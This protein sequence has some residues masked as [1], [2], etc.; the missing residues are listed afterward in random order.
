MK[1]SALL[2]LEWLEAR[3]APAQFGVPWPDPT[4]LT[5][6]FVPDGTLLAG[7]QSTLFTGLGTRFGSTAWQSAVLRAVE[8]WTQAANIN[9]GLVADS[10][11]PLG[12]AGAIQHD[13]RFGDLRISGAPL[14]DSVLGTGEPFDPMAGTWSGDIEFNTAQPFA[15]GGLDLYTVALHEVGHALGLGES[16]DPGSVMYEAYRGPRQG[17][18]AG[19]VLQ[20]QQLYGARQEDAFDL[21]AANDSPSTATRLTVPAADP[22]T[23][24]ADL[25]TPSDVDYYQVQVPGQVRGATIRLHVAGTSLLAGRLTILGPD[26]STATA[27]GPGQDLEVTSSSLSAGHT[28]LIRVDSTDTDFAV[29]AY[30]LEVVPLTEASHSAHS[31]SHTPPEHNSSGQ[32]PVI[33]LQARVYR[34]GLTF[35]YYVEDSLA[36]AQTKTYRFLAPADPGPLTVLAWSAQPGSFRPHLTLLDSQGE[37]VEASVLINQDGTYMLQMAQ[38][39]PGTPYLLRVEGAQAGSYAVGILFDGEPAALTP[40][41]IDSP[42]SAA[43]DVAGTLHVVDTQLM[44]FVFAA[45]GPA[46]VEVLD[47]QGRLVSSLAATSAEPVT[48]T[49]YLPAGDYTVRLAGTGQASLWVAALSS[50]LGPDAADVRPLPQSLPAGAPTLGFSWEL[51]VPL[52]STSAGPAGPVLPAG[53]GIPTNPVSGAAAPPAAALVPGGQAPPTEQVPAA[54]SL[55]GPTAT[56]PAAPARSVVSG[57]TASPPPGDGTVVSTTTAGA[58]PGNGAPAG[59][60]PALPRSGPGSLTG[61]AKDAVLPGPGFVPV[62]SGAGVFL[63][64]TSQAVA[65]STVAGGV[66][67]PGVQALLPGGSG[68]GPG[69]AVLPTPAVPPATADLV[70]PA[71]P[72]S[73]ATQD[74]R[75]ATTRPAVPAGDPAAPGDEP[76]AAVVAEPDPVATPAPWSWFRYTAAVAGVVSVTALW[77]LQRLVSDVGRRGP[78]A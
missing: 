34:D 51:N 7:Q 76:P 19:D 8:T 63:A 74:T 61:A 57:T 21:Q 67:G 24:A 65:G 73:P 36:T 33:N 41:V 27:T 38:S 68:T 58:P 6:S 53:A 4:H 35:A 43:G 15:P 37:P 1:S 39:S 16:S 59:V 50:P 45:Q 9:V 14:G 44:H 62:L 69:E 71:V 13:S 46:Q 25:T 3:L 70:L 48:M 29:G 54:P 28:L 11:L 12:T 18:S 66:P 26:G 72:Q 5:L 23:F 2:G 64:P 10:G 75:L 52:L 77:L 49:L 60:A 47:A 56:A 20:I 40:V 32:P 17:L 55:P 31:S 78:T 30:Q 22:S 42:L